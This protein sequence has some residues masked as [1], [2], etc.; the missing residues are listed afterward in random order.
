MNQDTPQ[1]PSQHQST[2]PEDDFISLFAEVF[3]LEKT[4][5]LVPEFPIR[6]I[7]GGARCIDFALRAGAKKIAFQVD[8]PT[9]YQPPAFDRNKY[10][11][12]LLRQNSLIPQGW[13]VYRWTDHELDQ[14]R[15]RVKEQLALFL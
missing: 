11:D 10:E 15:E 7:E 8:G 9:H 4:Q 3:G 12:D 6:D 2:Q 5:L 1:Q 14:R 13:Q